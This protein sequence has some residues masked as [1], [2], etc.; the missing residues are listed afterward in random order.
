MSTFLRRYKEN[1][2]LQKRCKE[3]VNILMIIVFAYSLVLFTCDRTE[4]HGN[5]MKPTIENEN[6]VLINRMAY[7]LTSPSRFDIVAFKKRGIQSN[8]VYVKRIIGVPGDTI[9]IKDKQI[10]VNGELLSDDKYNNNIL[11]PGIAAQELK[12]KENEYFLMGDNRNNSED[13]RFAN[14]GLVK[15]EDIIGTVW[16]VVA[17]FENIKIIT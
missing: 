8:K 4:I 9:Q 15:K 6:T 2:L 10:Y 1:V 16:M 7:A 14:I 12:L 17:P 13:S 11:T 3:I 5:S